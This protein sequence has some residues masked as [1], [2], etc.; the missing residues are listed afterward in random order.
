MKAALVQMDICFENKQKNTETALGYIREA[1]CSGADIVLFPEMTLTGFSMNTALT[2]EENSETADLMKKAASE[3][4]IAVGFGW[5]KRSG[6][7][8][9]NHYTVASADG[10]ILSDYVKIHPFSYSGEDRYFNAGDKLSSFTLCGKKISVF[11]CYDLRFPE[12][13]QAA[14]EESEVIIVAANWPERR[15][16]HWKVLLRARAIE[17]QSWI[18]GVNCFGTQQNLYYSGNTCAVRPDGTTAA[19]VDDTAGIIYAEISDECRRARE[20]FPV[21]KDRRTELYRGL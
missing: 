18:L 5:V 8:A 19:S 7:K 11:I 1:A 6:E 3:N 21:K 14:S 15:S 13:F 9:E 10:E 17:N 4:G 2:A 20:G 16:E 12:I